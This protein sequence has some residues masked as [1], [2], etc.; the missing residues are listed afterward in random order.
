MAI[1][2]N[3]SYNKK[4]IKNE[5][6]VLRILLLKKPKDVRLYLTKSNY[7]FHNMYNI[8]L[9]IN[10]NNELNITNSFSVLKKE[11]E[12]IYREAEFFENIEFW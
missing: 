10:D 2:K 4:P 12:E 9:K 8:N 1:F 3:K 11:F 7:T 6:K 5:D